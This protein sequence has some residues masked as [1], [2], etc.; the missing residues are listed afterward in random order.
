[1]N[2]G[3]EMTVSEALMW[4]TERLQSAE[5]PEA[6]TEAEWLLAHVLGTT[7]TVLRMDAQRTLSD[8][9]G[10]RFAALVAERAKRVP[11]A[12]L[13]G[14][15]PFCGLELKVDRRVMI[16]RP[17]TEQLVDIVTERLKKLGRERLMIADI[18]TGS[19]AIALALAHRFLE[20]TVYGVDISAEALEVAEE[21]AQRLGLQ[22]RVVFLR[23]DLTEPLEA[24]FPPHTF[25]AL[26]ANLPYVA[27][28][29]WERLSPE[30]RCYEPPIALRGGADG[31]AVVK[32]L[33]RRPLQRLLGP[34]GIVALELGIGQ[35]P[36]VAK[37][38][39]GWQVTVLADWEKRERFLIA[40]KRS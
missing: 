11:L 12:Y 31:L 5:V 19:G 24:I 2:E 29:E 38:L 13:L 10:E 6:K 26:V 1:M 30:V 20:A 37:W 35:P 21:N 36:I 7:R 34:C 18:G 25:D 27:D 17:E 4:A 3:W 8:A 28:A 39:Q 40:Q 33:M 16:P 22:K 9:E 32:R 23:G 15:Q 14:T